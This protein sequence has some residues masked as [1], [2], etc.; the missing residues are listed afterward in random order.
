MI[1][2][3]QSPFRACPTE[4]NEMNRAPV[5]FRVD[6]APPVGYESLYRCVTFAAALRSILRQA[7]LTP[8]ESEAL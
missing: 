5:L 3:G 2:G 1:L 8:Q 7:M 4:Q 6:A